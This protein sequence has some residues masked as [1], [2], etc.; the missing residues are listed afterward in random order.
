[1]GE[2]L[3]EKPGSQFQDLTLPEKGALAFFKSRRGVESLETAR[4]LDFGC[5]WG[6]VIRLLY[7]YVP[8]ENIFAV[9]PWDEP[10]T[11]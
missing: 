8:Y 11:L 1:M 10:I 4:V 5:G 6:R 2:T 9:D 7:K 3:D